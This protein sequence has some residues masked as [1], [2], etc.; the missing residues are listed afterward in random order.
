MFK[1][2]DI[3]NEKKVY[4]FYQE[5]KSKKVSINYLINNAAIDSVPKK[6]QKKNHLQS[7]KIWDEEIGVSLT[8]SY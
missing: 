8:G 2:L 5:L 7:V 3:S 1:Q 4:E 6:N